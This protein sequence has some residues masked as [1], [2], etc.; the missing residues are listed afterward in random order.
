M[1]TT[2]DIPE[3]QRT[4]LLAIAAERGFKGI[5]PIIQEALSEYLSSRAV[6]VERITAALSMRGAFDQTEADVLGQACG[7]IREHWR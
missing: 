4:R 5:S 7:Q 3:G 6:D 2:I 1:R